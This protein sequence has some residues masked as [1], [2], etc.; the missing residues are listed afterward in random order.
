MSFQARGTKLE[1][2]L[3]K[4]QHTQ[5]KFWILRIGLTRSLSRLQKSE[6][7]KLII[8]IAI[9]HHISWLHDVHSTHFAY[10][11]NYSH[12]AA[13]AFK[14]SRKS[15]HR[16]NKKTFK[17][18]PNLASK[19]SKLTPIQLNFKFKLKFKFKISRHFQKVLKS[20]KR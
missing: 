15:L 17:F 14:Q 10:L 2:F 13:T 9:I 8:R 7:L 6:F 1:I 20:S 11:H 3:P 12:S 4:N 19:H 5:R 16:I 18:S